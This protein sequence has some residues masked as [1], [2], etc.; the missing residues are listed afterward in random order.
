MPATTPPPWGQNVPNPG[1]ITK[2]V[3]AVSS[4]APPQPPPQQAIPPR[5]GHA[6]Q[7]TIL[8]RLAKCSDCVESSPVAAPVRARRCAKC[9]C[10]VSKFTAI[11]ESKCPLGKW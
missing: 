6:D 2:A 8:I 5:P 9:N 3:L 1:P 4:V 7:G 10:F 11:P